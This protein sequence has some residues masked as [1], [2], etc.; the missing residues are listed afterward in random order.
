VTRRPGVR[1]RTTIAERWPQPSP[2]PR[3]GDN[4]PLALAAAWRALEKDMAL[5]PA[6]PVALVTLESASFDAPP[7][8]TTR[9]LDRAQVASFFIDRAAVSNREYARFVESGGYQQPEIWPA[10]LLPLVLQLVDSTGQP[11]PAHWAGGQP[12]PG[13]LDHPVVGVCWFEAQAFARW[14]GKRLPTSPE[15][16]RAGTWFAAE[17]DGAP[18]QRYPWG[19][20]F[21]PQRANTWLSG[22]RATVP[23]RD[24]VEGCTPSGVHQLV[25]NVWEWVATPFDG[26]GQAPE[27]QFAMDQAMGEIRGGAFDTYFPNQATCQYRSGQ[28]LMH[29]GQNLG[30]RCCVSQSQLGSPPDPTAFFEESHRS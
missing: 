9:R 25:G 16:Q 15:W 27:T 11:G 24:Y 21:D 18:E 10:E 19:N 8:A 1:G 26:G 3:N 14:L 29:R 12:R 22:K 2:P 20:S 28:P 5:V 4:D 6:G 23:A 13:T 17:T 7:T 30:F